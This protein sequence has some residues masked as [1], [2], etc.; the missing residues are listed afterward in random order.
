MFSICS[1]KLMHALF[2]TEHVNQDMRQT[3]RRN[4]YQPGVTD[5]TALP[6]TVPRGMLEYKFHLCGVFVSLHTTA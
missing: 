6:D 3:E 2:H 5:N 4:E 1:E